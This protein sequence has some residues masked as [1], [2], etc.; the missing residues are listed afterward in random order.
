MTKT[1]DG[2][3]LPLPYNF[4]DDGDAFQILGVVEDMRRDC[5]M[6][7][8]IENGL[9]SLIESWGAYLADV[10]HVLARDYGNDLDKCTDGDF[11]TAICRG[12]N[13]QAEEIKK[14]RSAT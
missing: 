14:K 9:F 11:F 4:P 2:Q 6:H 1:E 5:T 3:M 10:A 7:V 12:F 8:S 13:C